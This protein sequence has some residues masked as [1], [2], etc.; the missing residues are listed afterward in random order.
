MAEKAK[1]VESGGEA[2]LPGLDLAAV[3]LALAGTSR[4]ALTYSGKKDEAAKHFARATA[5]DLTPSEKSELARFTH[6]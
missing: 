2:S 5:L 1:A 6:V 3:A 4:K